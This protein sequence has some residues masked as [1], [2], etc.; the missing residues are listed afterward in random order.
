MMG[1][2]RKIQRSEIG[3]N[4]RK[5]DQE[6]KVRE[7]GTDEDA[8]LRGDNWLDQNWLHTSIVIHSISRA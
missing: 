7:S 3:M 8:K 1:M 2:T 4:N 5:K 6:E